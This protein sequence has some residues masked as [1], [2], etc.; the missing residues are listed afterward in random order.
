MLQLS[1]FSNFRW[2]WPPTAGGVVPPQE[3]PQGATPHAQQQASTPPGG[4]FFNN[5]YDR[6]RQL[7]QPMFYDPRQSQPLGGYLPQKTKAPQLALGAFLPM[8]L[9][10]AS[11]QVIIMSLFFQKS[12]Y[13]LVYDIQTCLYIKFGL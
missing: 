10:R 5:Y 3:S 12:T 2:A 6:F 4:M 8:R 7:D 1:K 11:P 9:P 13:S